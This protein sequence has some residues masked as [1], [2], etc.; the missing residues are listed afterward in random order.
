M[1]ILQ[2]A[3]FRVPNIHLSRLSLRRNCNGAVVPLL[4]ARPRP[5]PH[6]RVSLRRVPTEGLPVV[7][8]PERERERERVVEADRRPTAKPGGGP[9]LLPHWRIVSG[10]QTETT[11]CAFIYQ[12]DARHRE[13]ETARWWRR[14]TRGRRVA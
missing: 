4:A 5:T 2:S 8:D 6:T 12:A 3:M 10:Y 7:A 1:T 11:A 13:S 14:Q 9:P